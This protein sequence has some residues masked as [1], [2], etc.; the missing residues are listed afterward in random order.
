MKALHIINIRFVCQK[1]STFVS[2]FIEQR[3]GFLL[4][5]SGF[6][7]DLWNL[8]SNPENP[9]SYNSWYK[10]SYNLSCWSF[11]RVAGGLGHPLSQRDTLDRLPV[12]HRADTQMNTLTPLDNLAPLNHLRCL[13]FECLWEETGAIRRTQWKRGE[14]LDREDPRLHRTGIKLRAFLQWSHSL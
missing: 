10:C 5:V 7:M 6:C 3:F 14:S 1:Y 8:I 9:V 2:R 13:S 12:H 11:T 4:D